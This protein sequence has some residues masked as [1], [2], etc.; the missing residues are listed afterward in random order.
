MRRVPRYYAPALFLLL[1]FSYFKAKLDKNICKIGNIKCF[2]LNLQV[3]HVLNGACLSL[4]QGK[5]NKSVINQ[6]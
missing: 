3:S 1:K 4:M 5:H 2:S 6:E